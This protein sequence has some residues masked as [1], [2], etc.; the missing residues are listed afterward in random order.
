MRAAA[1]GRIDRMLSS[2]S[3]LISDGVGQLIQVG[4]DALEIIEAEDRIQDVADLVMQPG[5]GQPGM[6]SSL[7]SLR[8]A[9]RNDLLSVAHNWICNVCAQPSAGGIVQY[10]AQHNSCGRYCLHNGIDPLIRGYCGS[11]FSSGKLN[12]NHNCP[13]TST[14]HPYS[15]LTPREDFTYTALPNTPWMVHVT[16]ILGQVIKSLTSGPEIVAHVMNLAK[17]IRDQEVANG[18]GSTTLLPDWIRKRTKRGFG[19]TVKL[20]GA[21]VLK[22]ILLTALNYA[23]NG[24]QDGIVELGDFTYRG[25]PVRVP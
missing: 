2:V 18:M 25:V 12:S 21:S 10:N 6:L 19:S 8:A 4:Y 22:K 15:R 1:P 16:D 20:L 13:G 3:G 7:V 23:N 17:T 14:Q 24:L 9:E 11:C 5:I